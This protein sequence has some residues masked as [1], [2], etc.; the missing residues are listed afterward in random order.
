MIHTKHSPIKSQQ[1][2]TIKILTEN[3]QLERSI[4][5]HMRFFSRTLGTLFKERL[6]RIC[7]DSNVIY[8]LFISFQFAFET[9]NHIICYT[10]K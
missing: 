10:D 9:F 4:H 5:L 7:F 6:V 1:D 2:G 8:Y 3:I